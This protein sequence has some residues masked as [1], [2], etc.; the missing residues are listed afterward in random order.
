M[1]DFEKK[2]IMT[3]L[4]T[5]N[6]FSAKPSPSSHDS[7]LFRKTVKAT[8]KRATSL[9]WQSSILGSEVD[10]SSEE[11]KARKDIGTTFA[12]V[13]YRVLKMCIHLLTKALILYHISEVRKDTLER[14]EG[15]I[16]GGVID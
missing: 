13:I 14:I 8:L 11:K 5:N 12:T 3:E 1:F 4:A 10:R 7:L 9:K 6:I 2:L 15:E 16:R